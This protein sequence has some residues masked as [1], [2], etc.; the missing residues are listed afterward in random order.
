L[1]RDLLRQLPC[2]IDADQRLKYGVV[3][4]MVEMAECALS[5]LMIHL[6][7][8]GEAEQDA[9]PD[10]Q[11]INHSMM[12][13]WS[14]IDQADLLR[15]LI[16]SE[17]DAILIREKGPFL[18]VAAD[19]KKARNWMRHI[20]QRV[21][22]YR[23]KSE[24]MPPILGA[25]SFTKIVNATV[26]LE[27]GKVIS[28]SHCLEYHAIVLVNT[29]L[30]RDTQFDGEPIQYKEF[31][32]PIDNIVL[33]A[34]GIALPL[35]PLVQSMGAFADALGASIQRWLDNDMPRTLPQHVS[36]AAALKPAMVSGDIYRMVARRDFPGNR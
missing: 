3:Q 35:K 16:E 28:E 2:V 6:E 31:K 10:I 29:A 4:A 7:G 36:L 33:Q 20:P 21:A 24:A 8:F 5:A 19:V 22:D 14:I 17:S 32:V 26:P 34:F 9:K 18:K 15:H 1:S 27:R 25:L 12:L 13:A 23:K 11:K 30:E